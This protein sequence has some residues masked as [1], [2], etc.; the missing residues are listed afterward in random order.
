MMYCADTWFLLSLFN[1]DDG[2]IKILHEVK[3]EKARLVISMIVYAET[4]K[5]LM[6]RGIS[7]K[8]I[9]GFFSGLDN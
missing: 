6:R 1:A 8:I 2:A 5:K 7:E 3:N 9:E 4:M